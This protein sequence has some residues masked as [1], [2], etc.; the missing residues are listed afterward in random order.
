M[1][2]EFPNSLFAAQLAGAL[3]KAGC[4]AESREMKYCGFKSMLQKVFKQMKLLRWC[5]SRR[6]M[7]ST[8]QQSLQ[9]LSPLHAGH[10]NPAY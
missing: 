5:F 9:S 7:F 6:E 3:R 1:Y 2:L 8:M 10:H 4:A